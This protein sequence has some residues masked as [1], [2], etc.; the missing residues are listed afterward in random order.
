MR[1]ESNFDRNKA[2]SL[3]FNTGVT[4]A[5]CDLILFAALGLTAEKLQLPVLMI[6]AFGLCAVIGL[7]IFLA[8]IWADF[9][10]DWL[11]M[12]HDEYWAE[13]LKRM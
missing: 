12:K 7:A 1:M 10:V 4:A 2:Y 6:V 5:V 13:E 8:F 9:I 3:V 11:E